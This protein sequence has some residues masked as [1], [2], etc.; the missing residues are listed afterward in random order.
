VLVNPP[1]QFA[2]VKALLIVLGVMALGALAAVYAA[3]RITLAS[4]ELA[5]DQVIVSIFRSAFWL[6]ML[7]LLVLIPAVMW[8]GI[9]LTHKVAGPLVRIFAVLEQ[10]AQGD[11]NVRI[12]LRK[13]DML[14][15]LAEAINRLSANIRRQLKP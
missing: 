4:F 8:L 1:L 12:T 15:D 5:H 6:I 7:E 10:M 14:V 2:F 11:Y 13:G 3:I 9:L